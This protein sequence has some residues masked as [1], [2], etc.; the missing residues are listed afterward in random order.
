ME[1]AEAWEAEIVNADAFQIYEGLDVLSAKPTPEELSRAPHH[2]FSVVPL[3]EEFDVAQYEEVAKACIEEIQSRGRRPLVVGGSGL[4]L[5]S[6]THGLTPLPPGDDKLRAEFEKKSL[7]DLAAELQKRDPEGAAVVN[8]KNRRYVTRALEIT[9]LAGRPMS[10]IK[11]EWKESSP[12]FDGVLLVRER[13][14]LYDRIN[15]RT[16]EM[17]KAGAL[18]EV[19]ELPKNISGTA[20]KAIG[21]QEIRAY[22]AGEIDRARCIELIQQ[23][24]RRYAKRQMNWFR[25]ET[26]FQQIEVG[27]DELPAKTASRISA[28]LAQGGS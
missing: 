23:N 20:A 10:E 6:L 13:E 5:K 25:R 18:E 17:M 15:V 28:I 27:E 26:G 3:Q 7:E 16:E 4:Y 8:L 9:I 24:T 22:Q 12:E 19:L 2:L 11:N 1:L 14:L 21:V